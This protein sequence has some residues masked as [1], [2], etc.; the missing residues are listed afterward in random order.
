MNPGQILLATILLSSFIPGIIIFGLPEEKHRLRTI[1]NLCG[2]IIKISL[3][4]VMNTWIYL[5]L[6]FE[7]R[8]PIIPGVELLLNADPLSALFASLSSVLLASMS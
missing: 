6:S 2:S 5:G 7:I 3:I 8:I 1:L 4:L